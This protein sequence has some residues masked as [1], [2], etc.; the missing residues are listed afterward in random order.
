MLYNRRTNQS[1]KKS[2]NQRTGFLA[3]AIALSGTGCFSAAKIPIEQ[4][5]QP[6]PAGAPVATI[7]GSEETQ[8]LVDNRT[9]Y[10]AGI[11]GKVVM[12]GREGWRTPLPIPAGSHVLILA[13]EYGS[14]SCG[15]KLALAASP[16]AKYQVRW[17]NDVKVFGGMSYCNFWV[18]DL[19]TD[20]AVTGIA[21]AGAASG[22][23][24]APVIVPIH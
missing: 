5:Y 20:K 10:V 6:P 7:L 4:Q 19:A 24:A 12:A 21:Q 17:D 13:Y 14:S 15:A 8:P 2:M 18:A 3:I 1:R 16:G 9:G 23:T 11:D 22:G